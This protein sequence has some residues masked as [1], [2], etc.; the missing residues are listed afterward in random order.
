MELSSPS[1]LCHWALQTQWEEEEKNGKK[2]KEQRHKK[3]GMYVVTLV[4]IE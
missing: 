2:E 4:G 3:I 1:Q